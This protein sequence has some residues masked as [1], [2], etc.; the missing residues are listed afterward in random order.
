MEQKLSKI[1]DIK[2]GVPE[3]INMPGAELKGI[4]M[5]NIDHRNATLMVQDIETITTD[6]RDS[7]FLK[8]GD[9]IMVGKGENNTAVMIGTINTPLVATNHFFIITVTDNKVLPQYLAWYLNNPAKQYL[10]LHA[11][12]TV[13]RNLRKDVIADLP[14]QVPPIE[15]QETVIN[16]WKNMIKEQQVFEELNQN[17]KL[18]LTSFINNYTH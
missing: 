4:K 15:V 17:R 10:N 13:I 5:K 8:Q 12:G 2:T 3:K 14:V 16:T 11:T 9:V 1:A 6:A 7:H 18:L